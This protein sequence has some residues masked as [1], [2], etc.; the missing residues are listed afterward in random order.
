MLGGGFLFSR[1]PTIEIADFTKKDLYPIEYIDFL[2]S[3]VKHNKTA[4][5]RAKP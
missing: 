5:I 3:T 4:R 2:I 1:I